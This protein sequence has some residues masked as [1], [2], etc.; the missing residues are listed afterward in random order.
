VPSTARLWCAT[1]SVEFSVFCSETNCCELLQVDH[2]QPSCC[3]TLP[4]SRAWPTAI[5]ASTL[6]LGYLCSVLGYYTWVV[7]LSL[8]IR[9]Q[10]FRFQLCSGRHEIAGLFAHEDRVQLYVYDLSNGLARKL[11]P[12][13]LNKQ[14]V[15][16]PVT[17]KSP[18]VTAFVE[19]TCT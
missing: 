14:V 2:G 7:Y 9:I 19:I 17:C 12:L 4:V 16:T 3:A 11:S 13:L 15:Q 8:A 18:C 1:G 10:L 6:Y 5:S